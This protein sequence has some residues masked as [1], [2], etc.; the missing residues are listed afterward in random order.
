MKGYGLALSLEPSKSQLLQYTF[1]ME[2]DL[3]QPGLAQA[4]EHPNAAE[5]DLWDAYQHK[6]HLHEIESSTVDPQ[7]LGTVIVWGSREHRP[8][9]GKRHS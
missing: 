8:L 9:A 2:R 6:Q 5:R 1:Q 3:D 4:M 7:E